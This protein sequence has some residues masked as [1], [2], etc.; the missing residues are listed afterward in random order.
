MYVPPYFALTNQSDTLAF[1]QRYNFATLV[2]AGGGAPMATH[3][4]FISE[5]RDQKLVLISH[6]ASENLQ[7][8]LLGTCEM[9]VI[10][11]EPHAYI[12]PTNYEREQNVPT[13]NYIAVHCYGKAVILPSDIEKTAVLEKMISFYESAYMKQWQ[14]LSEKYKNSMLAELVAFEIHVERIEAAAKMSQNKTAK[15]RENIIK[16]LSDSTDSTARDLA[17]HMKKHQ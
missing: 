14:G 9:L 12:S 13:W 15:E 2:S 6:M 17:E 10:F 16:S 5:I 4:P 1:I 3:L 8:A 11:A 7:A